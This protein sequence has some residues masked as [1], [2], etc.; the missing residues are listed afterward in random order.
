MKIEIDNLTIGYGQHVVQ[1]AMTAELTAGTMTCLIGANG[2]GKST[3]LKTLCGFIK[4]IGGR[5]LLSKKISKEKY[6]SDSKE[7]KNFS[8]LENIPEENKLLPLDSFSPSELASVIGIVLTGRPQVENLT[9]REMVAMGRMP[10]TGFF[11]SLHEADEKAIDEA[12][13]L[14]GITALQ[15]RRVTTLSDG[16]WH[17]MM[18]AKVLAQNTP[19]IFLDEPTAFLD[20]PSKVELLQLLRRLAGEQNKIV[21]LSTHDLTLALQ[22]SDRL[23]LLSPDRPL[24]V[25]SPHELAASGELS[26]YIERDGIKL[27]KKTL[28]IK[29]PPS[30]PQA[31][32]P[33]PPQ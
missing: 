18:V 15:R 20:F 28:E 24:A 16:E 19:V 26:H 27:N 13:S 2:A 30:N 7:E 11:G 9:V 12:L 33:T 21:F 31:P 17:K 4:P 8:S 1:K 32:T 5:I 22:M 6:K 14:T 23:W 29:A 3:L 25:G 10:Y